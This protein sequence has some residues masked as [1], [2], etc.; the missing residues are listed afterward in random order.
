[1]DASSSQDESRARTAAQFAT[2]HWSVVLAGGDDASPHSREAAAALEALC[3]QYWYPLY[4]FV[5]RQGLT[6]QDAEDRVQGFFAAFLERKS[7]QHA[8]PQRGRFRTFLLACLKNYL[9][10]EYQRQHT[11][12]RGGGVPVLS[13]EELGP[14]ELYVREGPRELTPEQLYD[15]TWAWGVLERVRRRLRED[16]A[17]RDQTKRFQLLEDFLPG[18]ASEMTYADAGRQL[19]LAEGSV[20]AEVHRLKSRYR[21]L[22]RAEVMRTVARREDVD[23][24]VRALTEALSV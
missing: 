20:K 17:R 5:R 12:K 18:E 1:M 3:R 24:E 4:A 9:A 23:D 14:E 8:D 7:V 19:G 15:R 13:M 10:K 6:H 2:T 21:F 11:L 16:Y 22:L